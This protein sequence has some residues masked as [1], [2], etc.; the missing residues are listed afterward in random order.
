[1][2]A[3]RDPA[4]GTLAAG[5]VTVRYWAAA[6]EAAGVGEDH[7][8]AGT[9]GEALARVRKIH[10][11]SPRFDEVLG[12]SSLLLGSAPITLRDVDRLTVPPGGVVE[13]LPPFGGG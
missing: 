7:V 3:R 1:V 2:T 8:D 9:V 12:L 4:T 11:D 10:A 6:R 5:R 13:V